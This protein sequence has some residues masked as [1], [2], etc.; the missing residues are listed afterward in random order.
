[1]V[2]LLELDEELEELDELLDSGEP[3]GS[4]ATV[5]VR[6]LLGITIRLEPGGGVL[7]PEVATVAASVQEVTAMVSGLCC[8]GT[9]TVLTPGL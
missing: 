9:T 1:M 8:L 7:V 5:W 6:L 3:Q 4:M 2:A